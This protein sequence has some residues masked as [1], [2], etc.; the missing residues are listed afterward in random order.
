MATTTIMAKNNKVTR[1]KR[2]E[3]GSKKDT[4]DE[5]PMKG[6]GNKKVKKMKIKNGKRGK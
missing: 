5:D 2:K 6:Q 3:E 4:S 1:N